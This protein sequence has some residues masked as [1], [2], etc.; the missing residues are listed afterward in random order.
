MARM[1][2]PCGDNNIGDILTG[3]GDATDRLNPRQHSRSGN[4]V[5]PLLAEAV[6]MM[7]QEEGHR[8]FLNLQ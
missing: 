7:A 6:L 2:L 4:R 8:H 1:D 5:D 3:Y